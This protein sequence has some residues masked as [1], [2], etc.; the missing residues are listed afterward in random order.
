[1]HKGVD[2]GFFNGHRYHLK[3]CHYDGYGKVMT[4]NEP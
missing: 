4:E 2:V 3:S 1:M